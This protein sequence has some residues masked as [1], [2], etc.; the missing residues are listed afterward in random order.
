MGWSSLP[1]RFFLPTQGQNLSTSSF[2]LQVPDPRTGN[3]CQPPACF[4]HIR[5]L[6][7]IHRTNS[8]TRRPVAL[9]ARQRSINFLP[10]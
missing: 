5:P 6:S 9:D 4:L 10:S 7:S 8:S 3:M 1:L 2:K